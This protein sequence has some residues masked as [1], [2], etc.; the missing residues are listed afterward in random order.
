MGATDNCA[1]I[2]PWDRGK[3]SGHSGEPNQPQTNQTKYDNW[4]PVN[5]FS[6]IGAKLSVD[7]TTA[8][9]SDYGNFLWIVAFN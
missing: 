6:L 1:P 3:S 2:E 4:A 5:N 8:H 9:L 7:P